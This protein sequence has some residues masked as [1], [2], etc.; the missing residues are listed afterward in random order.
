MDVY[1]KI[2]RIIDVNII[3]CLFPLTLAIILIETGFKNRFQTKKIFNL[4]R[5]VIITYTLITLSY[6]LYGLIFLPDRYAIIQRATG[7][8][9]MVYWLMLFCSTLLPLS[10]IFK[11]LAKKRWYILLVCMFIKIGAFFE[12]FV[13]TV[14]SFHRDYLVDGHNY[15]WWNSPFVSILLIFLQGFL[16]ALLVLG[17]FEFAEKVKIRNSSVEKDV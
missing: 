4:I 6:Y 8:Y 5:W 10:L 12:I 15:D 9:R 11:K 1:D 2:I 14:T 16:L 13:I 17:A 7:P 3:Y